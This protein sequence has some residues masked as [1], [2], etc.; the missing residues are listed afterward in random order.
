PPIGLAHAAIYAW[1]QRCPRAT[2]S[3]E[4][5]RL[6]LAAVGPT[7]AEQDFSTGSSGSSTPPPILGEVD[8]RNNASPLHWCNLF[9]QVTCGLHLL[10]LQANLVGQLVDLRR[11]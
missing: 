1:W 7:A 11:K 3:V 9:H 8:T 6:G 4:R 2:G 10:L 5:A